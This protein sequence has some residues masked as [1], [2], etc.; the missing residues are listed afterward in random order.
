MA[1]A[2]S[3][4]HCDLFE[5]AKTVRRNVFGSSAVCI[6][7]SLRKPNGAEVVPWGAKQVQLPLD[8]RLPLRSVEFKKR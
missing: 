4:S 3:G 6:K 8:E 7:S 2:D 1:K 5:Q